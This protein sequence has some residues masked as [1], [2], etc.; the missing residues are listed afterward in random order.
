MT[1]VLRNRGPDAYRP[2]VYGGVVRIRRTLRLDGQS[3][4]ALLNERGASR[5]W[6]ARA[7]RQPSR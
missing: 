7:C 1:V 6:A 3:A 2:D 4:Y 5:A